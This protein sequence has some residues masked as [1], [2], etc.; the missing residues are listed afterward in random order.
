MD[1]AKCEGVVRKCVKFA[2]QKDTNLQ[3]RP[4]SESSFCFNR[5]GATNSALQTSRCTNCCPRPRKR[6]TCPKVTI[7]CTTMSKALRLPRN[8]HI[9]VYKTAPSSCTCHEKA[10]FGPPNLEVSCDPATK[11]DNQV[12]KCA[13][14]DPPESA[15]LRS[16]NAQNLQS[17]T[18]SPRP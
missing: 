11:S 10:N 1:P 17:D 9:E 6:A 8:L 4:F 16:R 7:H 2:K 12:R 14:L 13:R 15:S 5:R 3:H 18:P